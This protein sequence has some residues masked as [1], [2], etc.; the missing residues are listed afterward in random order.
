MPYGITQCYVPPGRYNTPA[1]THSK[2]GTQFSNPGGMQ[3]WVDLVNKLHHCYVVPCCEVLVA[4]C[5]TQWL[6]QR[7][8]EPIV[9]GVSN[10]CSPL[11]CP[12]L[13]GFGPSLIRGLL[14]P[15]ESAPAFTNGISITSVGFAG[16]TSVP[17]TQTDRQTNRPRYIVTSKYL[18]T[19]SKQATFSTAL[20][21]QSDSPIKRSVWHVFTGS[22]NFTCHPHVHCKWNEWF[23]TIII[24][25]RVL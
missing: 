12:F 22:H 11:K 7:L 13:E 24:I 25:S 21:R 19:I 8:D 3:G 23:C 9:Q 14:S 16:L 18:W 1:F 2:A 10:T 20:Y 17:N 4:S 6:E 5:P 15:R